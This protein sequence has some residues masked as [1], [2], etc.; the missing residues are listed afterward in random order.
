MT[1]LILKPE[2]NLQQNCSFFFLHWASAVVRQPET[3]QVSV[4]MTYLWC[5]RVLVDGVIGREHLYP[6]GTVLRTVVGVVKPSLS[7]VTGAA[8]YS[9]A[10]GIPLQHLLSSCAVCFSPSPLLSSLLGANRGQVSPHWG[11]CTFSVFFI[12]GCGVQSLVVY[13]QCFLILVDREWYMLPFGVASSSYKILK[14]HEGR[15]LCLKESS[16]S[17]VQINGWN[18]QCFCTPFFSSTPTGCWPSPVPSPFLCLSLILTFLRCFAPL[19]LLH[20]LIIHPISCFLMLCN[21]SATGG[22]Q[23]SFSARPRL[24]CCW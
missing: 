22:S 19:D 11:I 5:L 12:W 18:P 20:T 10:P 16:S 4:R 14:R 13:A 15:A 8:S 21:F 24:L 6:G 7:S 1:V 3:F 2:M 23:G 17:E 9:P